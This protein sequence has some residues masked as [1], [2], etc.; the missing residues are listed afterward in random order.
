MIPTDKISSIKNFQND[1]QKVRDVS[2]PV[3]LNSFEQHWGDIS[4]D[5]RTFIHYLLKYRYKDNWKRELL[6][7][8][9]PISLQ[10]LKSKI[11]QN[12]KITFQENYTYSY[13]AQTIRDDFDIE[14]KG[15]T[16]TKMIIKR[17]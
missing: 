5:Y 7:N 10:T 14:I 2:D 1:V 3:Y 15:P 6:E 4:S 8:Y 16:H 9:V 13:F 11:P 17:I 12:Y